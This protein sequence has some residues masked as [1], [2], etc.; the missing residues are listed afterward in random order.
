MMIII[1]KPYLFLFKFDSSFNDTICFRIFE[2]LL[3]FSFFIFQRIQETQCK[4]FNS[5]GQINE[6]IFIRPILACPFIEPLSDLRVRHK[7]IVYY[8]LTWTHVC[9]TRSGVIN[10]HVAQPIYKLTITLTEN[11]CITYCTDYCQQLILESRLISNDNW[12][13]RSPTRSVIIR[14]INKIGRPRSRSLVCLITSMITGRLIISI[15]K[16]ENEKGEN[17]PEKE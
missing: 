2:E 3:T 17:L 15:T 7:E 11:K 6:I 5:I 8:T 9:A 13:E 1:F 14:V 10:N 4:L 12:T 16:F